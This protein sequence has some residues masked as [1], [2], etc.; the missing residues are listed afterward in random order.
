MLKA[1]LKESAHFKILYIGLI[2]EVIVLKEKNIF[3]Q[4]MVFVHARNA[5]V[6]TALNLRERANDEGDI[7]LF[8]CDKNVQFGAMEKKVWI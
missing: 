2:N 3:S 4:V 8:L 7:D 1:F 6:K 5:T